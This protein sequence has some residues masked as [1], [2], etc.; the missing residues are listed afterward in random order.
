MPH[1]S[2]KLG[3]GKNGSLFIKK[4]K[5]WLII[6]FIF[7]DYWITRSFK[8]YAYLSSNLYLSLVCFLKINTPGQNVSKACSEKIKIKKKKMQ[9][10]KETLVTE[11]FSE[12]CKLCVYN[13]SKKM[14]RHWKWF[15]R[16]FVIFLKSTPLYGLHLLK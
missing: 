2:L 12:S 6:F 5:I 16:N 7:L 10:F 13:F 8:F 14:L 9:I 11:P 3:R 1:E 15:C 4:R